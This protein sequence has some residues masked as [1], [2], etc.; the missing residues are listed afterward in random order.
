MNT[1]QL[2]TYDEAWAFLRTGIEHTFDP[3]QK[4]DAQR[5]CAHEL[6]LVV[7]EVVQVRRWEK[8]LYESLRDELQAR[9][10]ACVSHCNDV[11]TV[12]AAWRAFSK[13]L[14]TVVT[15]FRCLDAGYACR[16]ELGLDSVYRVGTKALRRSLEQ[17]GLYGSLTVELVKMVR[18]RLSEEQVADCRACVE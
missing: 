11:K 12:A 3:V 18:A 13:A 8:A 15:V 1:W 16:T 17:R 14:G 4:A 10:D 2:T 5:P 6:S 7:R 9:A